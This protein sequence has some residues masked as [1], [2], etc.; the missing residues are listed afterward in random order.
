[1]PNP[2]SKLVDPWFPATALGLER[3]V[4]S[5][6][7]LDGGSRKPFTLRRA[8]S[9]SVSDSLIQP[10]FDESNISDLSQLAEVLTELATSAGL[11]RMRKWSVSLPE[12]S[13]KTVIL[14]MEGNVGSKS[15]LEE[16][17][18]WKLER[19]FGASVD[20][21]SISKQSLPKDSQGRERYL[22]V[23]VRLSVLAE[24]ESVFSALG[25]RAGLVLPRH[26]G[27]SRWL[28]RNGNT[29][30]SLLLTS[31]DDGF[32]AAIFRNR[33]PLI[34][35]SVICE[36]DEREDEFYRMLLFYRD[37]QIS[38]AASGGQVLSQLMVIGHGFGK[39]R[40]SEIA[41][42]T[43]GEHMHVLRAEDVGLMLPNSDLSFDAIAA[44]SGLATMHWL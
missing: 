2:F 42:E 13:M 1:M 24:Y 37:R 16:V 3:G 15:E 12:A 32:T 17:L 41:S 11:L 21:L 36:P 23:A 10:S 35:R 29:G 6:V 8:A 19:G 25:W 14:T 30:D 26:L 4:A 18:K 38:E 34:M 9:V 5:M 20:E 27:E 31:H 43:L 39:D 33:E 7:Q 44:P 28:T 40:A 22:A